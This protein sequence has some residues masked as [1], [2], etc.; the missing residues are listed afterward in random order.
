[1][2]AATAAAEIAWNHPLRHSNSLTAVGKCATWLGLGLRFGFGF[3]FGFA[4]GFGFGFGFG[5]GQG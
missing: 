1:M 4:F 3:G 2:P 5:V